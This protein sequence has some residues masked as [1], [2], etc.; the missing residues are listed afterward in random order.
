MEEI[1]QTQDEIDANMGYDELRDM[2]L[3]DELAE[4]EEAQNAK[5]YNDAKN[6]SI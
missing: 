4:K 6:G 1:F 2:Q 3:Q 5:H